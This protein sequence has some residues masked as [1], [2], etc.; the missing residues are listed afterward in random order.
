MNLVQCDI[1]VPQPIRSDWIRSGSALKRSICFAI[2]SVARAWREGAAKGFSV[3][4]ILDVPVD[5]DREGKLVPM[6]RTVCSFAAAM[7]IARW[8]PGTLRGTG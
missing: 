5:V 2:S 4:F 3:F 6:S 8:T 1:R 7:P